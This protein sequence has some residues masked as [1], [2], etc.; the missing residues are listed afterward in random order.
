MR[1]GLALSGGGLRATLFHLGVVKALQERGVLKDVKHITSVSGGSILAAHLV[2]NWAS[3]LDGATFDRA[4]QE[5]VAFARSDVRG[6]I[7]R[8]LMLPPYY[9]LPYVENLRQ[10]R[11]SRNGT[12]RNLLFERYL[13]GLLGDITIDELAKKNPEAPRLDILMTNLT[14]GSLAYFSNDSFVPSDDDNPTVLATPATPLARAVMAS[15][16]FPAVFPTIEFSAESLMV[17]PSA[18][19]SREYLTDGGVYDNLGIRRFQTILRGED[20]PVDNVLVCDASGAFNWLIERETLGYWQTAL[21]S[22][23]ILMKRLADLEYEIARSAS[24]RFAFVRISDTVPPSGEHELDEHVQ[25]QVKNVRTDLDLFSTN[26]IDMIVQHGYSVAARK[27]VELYGP[28]AAEPP[29]WTL[30]ARRR[31]PPQAAMIRSLQRA[32]FYSKNIFRLS[33]WPSYVYP[34]LLLIALGFAAHGGRVL[35]EEARWRRYYTGLEKSTFGVPAL[36]DAAGEALTYVGRALPYVSPDYQVEAALTCYGVYMAQKRDSP[37]AAKAFEVWQRAMANLEAKDIE[38][39]L[40]PTN[41]FRARLVKGHFH[42]E[43]G[44]RLEHAKAKEAEELYRKAAETYAEARAVSFG[45]YWKVEYNMCNASNAAADAA[46]RYSETV[47]TVAARKNVAGVI[48]GY[49]DEALKGCQKA[50]ELAPPQNWQPAF[51]AGL[52]Y[53]K[54]GQPSEARKWLLDGYKAAPTAAERATYVQWLAGQHDL[55]SPLCGDEA[56]SQTFNTICRG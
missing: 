56:F 16:L 13:K 26:E 40:N 51:V 5:I 32:R 12:V 9:L 27:V 25:R 7:F 30:F 39:R 34:A 35:F 20:C 14:R 19:P 10:K 24:N 44:N 18:F 53:M 2:E 55:I 3:Y 49:L 29:R 41:R 4:A 43:T 33:D 47:T 22:T 8:R 46:E 11:L 17:D 45:D 48:E 6:R 52:I 23:D 37:L 38:K 54:K 15:A 1:L 36:G 50:Q 21:R 42:L 28:P 31:R